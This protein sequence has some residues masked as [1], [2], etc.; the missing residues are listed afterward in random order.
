MYSNQS[1][2]NKSYVAVKYYPCTLQDCV[3]CIV[4][5]SDQLCEMLMMTTHS[6]PTTMVCLKYL[7]NLKYTG[8]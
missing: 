5:P 4:L 8:K 6:P 1:Q 3:Y 2:L 7:D